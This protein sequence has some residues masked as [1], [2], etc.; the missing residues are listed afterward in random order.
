MNTVTEVLNHLKSKGYTVDFNLAEGYLVDPNNDLRV[1][2]DDFEVDHHYRFE[3]ISDPDD[4]AIVY[5]ISSPK[6][7]VKG[8]LVNGYGIY[9]EETADAMVRTLAEKAQRSAMQSRE[10]ATAEKV[11]VATPQRPEGTRYLDAP[12]VTMDLL[13]LRKQIKEEPAWHTSDRNSITLLKSEG[14]RILLLA[15][16][17]GAQ[18]KEH[19]APGP[20]S[21]QVVE[22]HVTFH[23]EQQT[24]E[25]TEGQMVSLHAGI[26]HSVTAREESVFL[27]T[28]ATPLGKNR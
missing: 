23:T 13:A 3:G 5:A 21:V 15:L 14:L 8:T 2:P 28:I 22:G 11:N 6:H 17:P 7:G 26:P 12:M 9:S 18:L 10:T 25:L 24:A 19:T 16:Q 1:H 4:E 27:L 20:I